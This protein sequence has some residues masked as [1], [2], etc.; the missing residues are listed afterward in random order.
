MKKLKL[1]AAVEIKDLSK[2][3]FLV[4]AEP[5]DKEPTPKAKKNENKDDKDEKEIII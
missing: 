1:K 4:E 5:E 3:D 2:D